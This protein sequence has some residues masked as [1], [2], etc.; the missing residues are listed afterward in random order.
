MEQIWA[1][2]NILLYFFVVVALGC[3]EKLILAQE[4]NQAW[5]ELSDT[6]VLI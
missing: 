2:I 3:K 1:Y 4:L 6:V 5:L